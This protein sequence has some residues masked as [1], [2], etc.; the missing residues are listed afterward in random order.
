MGGGASKES[1]YTTLMLASEEGQT[2]T[3]AK[4]LGEEGVDLEATDHL[5]RTAVML[6]A[7]AGHAASVKLLLDK[8]AQ[9]ET[10]SKPDKKHNNKG[11]K[12]DLNGTALFLATAMGHVEVVNVLLEKGANVEAPNVHKVTALMVA[13]K[14]GHIDIATTL[15]NKGAAINAQDKN[16]KTALMFACKK[17]DTSFVKAL[18]D[19]GADLNAL[20]KKGNT[21]LTNVEAEPWTEWKEDIVAM[22][23]ARAS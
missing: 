23:K 20:D 18:L 19:K 3:V 22:L 13:A 21:V 11:E 16:G 17:G 12:K 7:Q 8:G 4:L 6:A 9:L 10:L 15:L 5:G 14:K 1:K 2:E